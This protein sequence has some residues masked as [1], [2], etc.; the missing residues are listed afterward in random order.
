LREQNSPLLVSLYEMRDAASFKTGSAR[1]A[2]AFA[3]ALIDISRDAPGLLEA[4]LDDRNRLF[5]DAIKSLDNA[6][7][8]LFP[9]ICLLAV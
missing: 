2:H 3:N 9:S 6:I 7:Q 8:V 4:A 1:E 5:S